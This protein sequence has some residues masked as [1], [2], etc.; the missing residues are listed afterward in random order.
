MTSKNIKKLKEKKRQVVTKEKII[1]FKWIDTT[2]NQR[3]KNGKSFGIPTKLLN[4]VT[5][6]AKKSF[7]V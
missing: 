3:K 5:K 2:S 1:F 6:R 7:I 4:P